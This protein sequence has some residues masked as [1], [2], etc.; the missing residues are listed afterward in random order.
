LNSCCFTTAIATLTWLG[1]SA[2][3]FAQS[4]DDAQPST[5]IYAPK[6][7]ESASEWQLRP[8]WRLQ[9]DVARMDGPD[10]LA[11]MGN[12]EDIRRARL[13]IDLAMP[14]GFSAR[15]ETELTADPVELSDAYLQW[16]DKRVKVILGQQKAQFPLDE[17]ISDLDTSF[18]ER[19]AFVAA[20]GYGRR[21]GVSGHYVTGDWGISGGIYTDALG[22]LNDVRANS[23]SADFR[24][25]WSPQLASTRLHFGA[26]YHWRDLNDFGILATRYRSRPALRITDTRYIAT[27]DLAVEKEQRFGVEAAAVQGRFHFAS[28]AH[29]LKAQ[30]DGLND[31]IF[32]GAYA[33]V[34]L[35]L[36]KDSRPLK[37]GM[38]GTIKPRKPIGGGGLGAVQLNL[39]YDYLDLNSG[40][41]IGGTQNG[42][43]A[44]LIWTP[45]ENFRLMGQYTKLQYTDAAVKVDG[46]RAYTV[47]VIGL[48]GQISF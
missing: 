15:L 19:A 11:G 40:A 7:A 44:S 30:R 45:A 25:Y 26:A 27:P 42:Y 21:T 3:A 14:H 48:R 37:G 24:A 13:G 5:D 8:R 46:N 39:R 18:L 33:E 36:T 43:L 17:E 38:F 20:F 28:E 9:Y 41:V 29:W 47:N 12:F 4:A 2:P 23:V 32:F 1:L 10:G 16:R 6:A 35:F 31:P 22:A 34:G